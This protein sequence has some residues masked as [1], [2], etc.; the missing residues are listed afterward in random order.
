VGR[1]FRYHDRNAG[2]NGLAELLLVP[3][4]GKRTGVAWSARG[5][6]L[7]LPALPLQL[8][9]TVQ[10]QASHARCWSATFGAGATRRNDA[11]GFKGAGD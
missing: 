11:A 8:P 9:V 10:V 1:G 3:S 4:A 6:T 5:E 7:V 2:Q